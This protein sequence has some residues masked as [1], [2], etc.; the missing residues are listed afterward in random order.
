MR[1][2][3]I[4]KAPIHFS[5]ILSFFVM[6]DLRICLFYSYIIYGCFLPIVFVFL[7]FVYKN[8]SSFLIPIIIIDTILYLILLATLFWLRNKEKRFWLYIIL[9]ATIILISIRNLYLF[10]A[11]IYRTMTEFDKKK[12]IFSD[13][14]HRQVRDFQRNRNCHYCIIIIR[15]ILLKNHNIQYGK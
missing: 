15:L 3:R 12:E 5:R 4:F 2:K 1:N 8:L 9:I 14:I 13:A 6:Y 7:I 10:I 11:I